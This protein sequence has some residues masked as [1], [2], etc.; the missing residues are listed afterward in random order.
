[1]AKQQPSLD[2]DNL[3]EGFV[4]EVEEK[5]YDQASDQLTIIEFIEQEVNLG[6]DLTLQQKTILKAYY[7]LPLTDEEISVL[8][9]WV[10]RGTCTWHPQDIYQSLILEAG[11]RSGKTT[12]CS[13]ITAYEFYKLCRMPCP[14]KHFRISTN[15]PISILVLATT[16]SQGKKTIFKAVAGIIRN[17]RYFNSLISSGKI[18]VG[19]E[20][21]TYEDKLLFIYSGNSQSGSQVGGT[22]KVLV[23][24]EVARFKDTDGDSNALELWSNLGI[25]TATFGKEARRIAISSA[26]YEGD[27]M[28]QLYDS[29]NTDATA[30]GIRA[31]SW[32]LNPVHA[33]R[34]NPVIASEYIRDPVQAALE[35]EGVRP[36]AEN[37]FLNAAEVKAAFRGRSVIKAYRYEEIEAGINLTKVRVEQVDMFV[38]ST[39]LHLDPAVATDAYACAFGHSEFNDRGMQIV[40]IDGLLAWEPTYN[41]QISIT[42][43]QDVV[44]EINRKRPLTKLTADHYNSH[45]TIQRLR[46]QGI[47]A[48]VQYFSNPTQ[49]AMYDLVRLLLHE[50]RLILPYD[51]PWTPLAMSELC[52]VQLLRNTKID[53]PV[54]GSKDVSDCIASVCWTLADRVT[55]DSLYKSGKITQVQVPVK[56]S[57]TIVPNVRNTILAGAARNRWFNGK[58]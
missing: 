27:A 13:L 29:T 33:A 58:R 38:G 19:K 50:S 47:P 16:A 11:R 45:E 23:M 40:V 2:F 32:D 51:S 30:L 12:L 21:I 10:A 36:A 25:S 37:P 7:N 9:F 1:V 20:E 4:R 55:R 46:F 35:F 56:S 41:S 54:N 5:I 42:N 8:E 44:L 14:Q 57:S 18:F 49:V 26:W 52:K 17:T 31:R 24:D 39:A 53:H 22:V 28:Q 43:V 48:E 15:T 6:I 34:D 3:F